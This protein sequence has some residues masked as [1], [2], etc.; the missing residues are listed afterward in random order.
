MFIEFFRE[1]ELAESKKTL[2]EVA[3]QIT[4]KLDELKKIKGR[5]GDGKGRRDLEDIL[6]IYT[7]LDIKKATLPKFFA[8]DTS[9]IPTFSEFDVASKIAEVNATVATQMQQ[10]S[11]QLS[12]MISDRV[13]EVKLSMSAQIDALKITMHQQTDVMLSVSDN[14]KAS[15]MVGSAGSTA[16]GPLSEVTTGGVGSGQSTGSTGPLWSTIVN[17][18]AVLSTI[19]PSSKADQPVRRKIIG[20]GKSDG[21]KLSASSKGQWNVFI[22]RLNKDTTE[23]DIKSFLTDNGLSVLEVRKLKTTQVWQEKSAAFRVSV[24]LSCKE[25]VMNADMWRVMWRLGIG[26]TNLNNGYSY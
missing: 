5:V 4:P 2:M 17:G 13:D 1:N 23:D 25:A 10:L 12:T 9:R 19:A 6:T 24:A 15:A 3:E 7:A 11:A 26:C 16:G 14:L 20:L 8:A 21:M 18:K 22:G